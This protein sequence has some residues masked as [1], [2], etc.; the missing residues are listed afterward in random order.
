[1]ETLEAAKCL[2]CGALLEVPGP[3]VGLEVECL[4][5]QEVLR[6]VE[7]QPLRLYYAFESDEEPVPDE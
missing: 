7:V 3:W 5:C 1:M 4:E 2:V 6:V